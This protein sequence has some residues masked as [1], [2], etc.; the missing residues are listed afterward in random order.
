MKKNWL[1]LICLLLISITIYF[2]SHVNLRDDDTHL[3]KKNFVKINFE[4]LEL[5]LVEDNEDQKYY[6][7]IGG[8]QDTV[9]F[10]SIFYNKSKNEYK[11]SRCLKKY[12]EGNF[13]HETLMNSKDTLYSLRFSKNDST[14]KEFLVGKYYFNYIKG[15]YSYEQMLFFEENRD[16]L[17]KVRGNHLPTLL[18]MQDTV[19][20]LEIDT[21]DMAVEE[22]IK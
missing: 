3:I 5:V 2:I 21:S 19:K 4:K 10:L 11:I 6:E 18:S 13:V 8:K 16:S 7:F 17:L 15:N 9:Q 1:F 20:Y 12:E 14:M 22:V